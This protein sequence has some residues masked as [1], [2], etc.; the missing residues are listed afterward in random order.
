MTMTEN[1]YNNN[2]CE[3]HLYNESAVGNVVHYQRMSYTQG[4]RTSNICNLLY[5]V[6]MIETGNSR[7]ECNV[8]GMD[9]K[10]N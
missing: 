9:G 7:R 10:K 2:I 1:G 5:K 8:D 6:M 4:A 3:G